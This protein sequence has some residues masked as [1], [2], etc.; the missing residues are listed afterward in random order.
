L[1]PPLSVEL[2]IKLAYEFCVNEVYES[3]TDVA[4]VVRV[5]GQ[6]EKVVFVF[7][8]NV[9]FIDQHLLAIFIGNVSDHDSSTPIILHLHRN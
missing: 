9:D 4:R 2:Q 3:I 5:Y 7:V 6:I 8:I 1:I